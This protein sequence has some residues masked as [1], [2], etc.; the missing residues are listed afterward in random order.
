MSRIFEN[1]SSLDYPG[2]LIIIGKDRS[3]K[4]IIAVYAITGRSPSSQ[5]RRIEQNEDVLWVKPTEKNMLDKDKLELLIYPAI[6]LSQGIAVSNG[7]QTKDIESFLK[8]S[9]NPV[10]VLT[11]SLKGWEY[12]PDPPI[13]TPRISGCVVSTGTA[14]L[15]IIK[16]TADGSSERNAF[17]IPLEAGKGKMISTYRG[18]DRNPLPSFVGEPLDVEFV[19]KTAEMT[20]NA[21]YKSLKPKAYNKDY[22]VSVACVFSKIPVSA[23][24]EVSIMNR[25][26]INP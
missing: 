18:E 23:E 15:S 8:Q 2:R 25:I 24:Y 4:N 16:R 13:F 12:E 6:F 26:V 14:A 10:E 17:E 1:L 7:K 5:A 3:E 22:R 20:A 9:K 21:V 19:E 11:S